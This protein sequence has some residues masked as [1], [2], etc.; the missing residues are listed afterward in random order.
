MWTGRL[1]QLQ[2]VTVIL[3]SSPWTVRKSYFREQKSQNLVWRSSSKVVSIQRKCPK[4]SRCIRWHSFRCGEERVSI[5]SNV[6]K[7]DP[8]AG[9]EARL[10]SGSAGEVGVN[11]TLQEGTRLSCLPYIFGWA[12]VALGTWIPRCRW[13]ELVRKLKE[14]GK[15]W[16][17]WWM[18][19][20]MTW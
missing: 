7:L 5:C 17:S 13:I 18:W 16:S 9:R 11:K 4:I 8:C 1:R 20:R 15:F 2:G 3:S 14:S 19:Q 12:L 10:W 6:R